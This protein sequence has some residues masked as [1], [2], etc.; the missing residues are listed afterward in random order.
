MAMAFE[1]I[2]AVVVLILAGTWLGR[3]EKQNREGN[4]DTRQAEV[5][6]VEQNFARNA[7]LNVTVQMRLTDQHGG[8]RPASLTE[9]IK[10]AEVPRP[11]DKILVWV[12]RRDP[13]KIYYQGLAANVQDGA[14]LQEVWGANGVQGR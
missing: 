4:C 9:T 12:D 2:G 3:K 10:T 5:M 1:I 7:F 11:G 14:R 8:V 6:T 13:G